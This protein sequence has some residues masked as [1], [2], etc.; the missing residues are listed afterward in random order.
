MLEGT[1]DLAAAHNLADDRNWLA[2]VSS[3]CMAGVMVRPKAF[4]PGYWLRCATC[5]AVW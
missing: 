1:P 4:A 2:D 3:L 5:H